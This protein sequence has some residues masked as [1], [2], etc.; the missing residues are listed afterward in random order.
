LV[1]ALLAGKGEQLGGTAFKIAA[2]CL[3]LALGFTARV[4]WELVDRP[5]PDVG[6]RVAVAQ[7]GDLNCADFA[8]QAEAQAVLDADPSDPN[9]LD[10]DND[11]V[12]CEDLPGGT[13]DGITVGGG[14]SAGGQYD[15]TANQVQYGSDDLLEAGGPATG[16][17]PLMPDGGCPEEYPVEDVGGC[18]R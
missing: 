1:P 14:T 5:A 11:G 4:G 8:T 17:V 18:Y 13:G 2:V 16:P 3:V 7:T 15:D 10:A 6:T 9:N 12:A